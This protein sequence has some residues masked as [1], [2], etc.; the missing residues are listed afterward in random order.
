MSSE[1]DFLKSVKDHGI[2][3]IRD[4]G[5]NRHIRFRKP[6]TM[7]MH[8]DLITWPGY[9]C[10]TGDMGTYVF[11]RLEDMFEFF[12]RRDGSYTIDFRY[13]A[14][15]LQA[16]DSSSGKGSATEFSPERFTRVINDYRLRWIRDARQSLTKDQRRELW[17]AVDE[18]VLSGYDESEHGMYARANDFS[19][20]VKLDGRHFNYRFTDL[21]DHRFTEYTHHFIWCCRALAW[22]IRKYDESKA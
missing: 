11:S 12:R 18:E 8:F 17:E 13:W 5:V 19:W 4:D 15:K 14:E 7:C 20:S 16:V 9:L 3:V 6:G 21:W 1:Q 10:Y 2:E 22:G